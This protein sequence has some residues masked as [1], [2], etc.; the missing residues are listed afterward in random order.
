[1]EAGAFL[2]AEGEELPEAVAG[3]APAVEATAHD[4]LAAYLSRARRG[5]GRVEEEGEEEEESAVLA[6]FLCDLSLL[7][8]DGCARQ[9]HPS[10]QAAAALLLARCT[11]AHPT[12]GND[13]DHD[14]DHSHEQGGARALALH[15]DRRSVFT[16]S[17]P[18]PP[19]QGEEEEEDAEPCFGLPSLRAF[20][21]SSRPEACA[22][23]ACAFRLWALLK[24]RGRERR[25]CASGLVGWF[26]RLVCRPCAYL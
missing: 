24:V 5:R 16:P 26:G 4:F 6:H 23:A 18:P 21:G 20:V 9:Y 2:L 10:T 11:A 3:R 8:D 1:M 12:T 22:V 14:H 13:D 17:P 19:S 15:P 7:D 25:V